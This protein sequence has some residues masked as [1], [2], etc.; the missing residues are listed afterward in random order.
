MHEA[1]IVQG[2]LPLIAES[3]LADNTQ[4]LIVFFVQYA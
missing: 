4:K 3:S 2:R 1:T